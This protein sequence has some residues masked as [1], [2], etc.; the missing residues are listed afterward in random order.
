MIVAERRGHTVE[1]SKYHQSVIV[2][3]PRE[4]L[5]RVQT[6]LFVTDWPAPLRGGGGGT[7]LTDSVMETA[8]S[9]F[10]ACAVEAEMETLSS[11]LS[12]HV[13]AQ[14]RGGDLRTEENENL[15]TGGTPDPA[16]AKALRGD[17]PGKKEAIE[18]FV[19]EWMRYPL[20]SI[21]EES[22][23]AIGFGIKHFCSV[24]FEGAP[25]EFYQIT[26]EPKRDGN[27]IRNN[28]YLFSSLPPWWG[29]EQRSQETNPS[30]TLQGTMNDDDLKK[31]TWHEFGQTPGKY[32]RELADVRRYQDAA[33]LIERYL[34]LHSE[35]AAADA[36]SL[37]FYAAQCRLFSMSGEADDI[38]LSAATASAIKHLQKAG[39]NKEGGPL[40]KEYLIGTLAFLAAK[41]DALIVVHC[42]L[43]K[44]A[45]VDK[46]NLQVLD[47]LLANFGKP[48]AEAYE[49]EGQDH[50]KLSA[51]C[52]NRAWELLDKK[53]RTK[54]DDE[55]MISLAHASL[56]HWRMRED[57]KD[58]H[59]SIGYWQ[60][61]RV[62]AVLGQGSNA[63]RYAGLCLHASGKE[64]PFYLAYAHEAL[65]RAALVNKKRE[66]FDSHLAEAKALAA[67]VSDADEK[68]MLADDLASLVWP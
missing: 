59:L 50:K 4:V 58:H 39:A 24:S 40:W 43:A 55:R 25:K 54:E 66:L 9:V 17:W 56:A 8:R 64:P 19:R 30:T 22:G 20:K 10:H 53:T 51:D 62:Y 36:A 44:S 11:M 47:R 48:Y 41:R 45:E 31:I 33:A 68:K 1:H 21:R 67:K 65:A 12:L 6:F 15:I 28:A 34:Y 16:W 42:Q 27:T 2:T 52:F 60:I 57:C 29:Q 32:W 46:A 26:I 13:L 7:Y 63:E 18:R 23:V 3:A 35:L 38:R 5:N 37:H 14:L 49:V 61:S